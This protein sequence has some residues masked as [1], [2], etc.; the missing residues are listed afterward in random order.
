MEDSSPEDVAKVK[1]SYTGKALAKVLAG[2][3]AFAG[4]DKSA[5]ERAP[6][7]RVPLSDRREVGDRSVAELLDG[8]LAGT[9]AT[10]KGFA[11]AMPLGDTRP[12]SEE[13]CRER[14]ERYRGPLQRFVTRAVTTLSSLGKL[15]RRYAFPSRP[16]RP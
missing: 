6:R 5:A 4:S 8:V 14:D 16:M 1:E 13:A 12:P 9:H 15:S 10:P 3:H 7:V 11:C 2:Q